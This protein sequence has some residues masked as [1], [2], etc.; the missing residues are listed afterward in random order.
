MYLSSQR[1]TGELITIEQTQGLGDLCLRRDY[2]GKP[3]ER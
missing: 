2:T 3:E 1:G